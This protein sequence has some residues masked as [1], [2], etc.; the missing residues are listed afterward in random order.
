M[1]KGTGM[2]V[3]EAKAE[4]TKAGFTS[5]KLTAVVPTADPACTVGLVCRQYPLPLHS[6]RET[7][8]R[9]LV[10]GAEPAHPPAPLPPGDKGGKAPGTGETKRGDFDF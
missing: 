9:S 7:T 3:D 2:T 6:H 5:E 4:I 1:P 8:K 10:V